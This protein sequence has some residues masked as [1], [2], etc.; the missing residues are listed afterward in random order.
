MKDYDYLIVGSGIFGATFACFAKRAGKKCL[1]VDK[2]PH[3]GGNLHCENI[4]G[5]NVHMYG[6]HVFHTS[7]REV[8]YFVNRI[9]PFNNFIN[10]PLSYVQGRYYPLPFNMNLFHD[11]WGVNTPDEARAIIREQCEDASASLNGRPPANV[12]EAALTMV[13]RE[14]YETFIKDYTEKQWGRPCSE[15]PTSIIKRVPLRFSYNNSYYNDPYQGIPEGGYNRLIDGLLDGI[16][17]KTGCNF[18]EHRAELAAKAERIV[19]TGPIDA[20]FD[21]CFGA[22]S[23]RTLLFEHQIKETSNWQGNPVINYP[24]RDVPYTRIVEHKHF[25]CSGDAVYANPKTVITYEYP[26]EWSPGAEP[27]YPVDSAENRARYLRYKELADRE[28][29]VLFGGRLA[30]YKYYD[31]APAIESAMRLLN[32]EQISVPFL[33]T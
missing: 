16:E 19:Y 18:L 6:P 25:E 12:E 7:N 13:G 26:A 24:S 14:I 27:Y 17:I 32:N 15:L 22:L 4:E 33:E 28:K 20:Y 30:E 5:I 11:L 29:N 1:I 2:R 3:A 9:V 23:W 31:M 10:A 8:W 21:Y